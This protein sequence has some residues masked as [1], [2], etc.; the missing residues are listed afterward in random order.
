MGYDLYG[1]NPISLTGV[2][3]RRSVLDW[4]A[5]AGLCLDLAEKET[6]PCWRWFTNDGDGLSAK[7]SIRLAVRL[8]E[9]L[10]EGA[11]TRYLAMLREKNYED[12]QFIRETDVLEFIAFLKECGG[13]SID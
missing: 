5:L 7:R 10:A 11:V 2:H 12:V 9:L 13:F 6:R 3:F 4:P 1:I 8:E